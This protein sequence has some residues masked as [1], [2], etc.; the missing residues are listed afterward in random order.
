[1]Q[2]NKPEPKSPDLF[3]A[4]KELGTWPLATAPGKE[5][6]MERVAWSV[7]R[8]RWVR[9]AGHGGTILCFC[10]A[11]PVRQSGYTSLFNLL[12]YTAVVFPF[13]VVGDK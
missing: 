3:L 11:Y 2:G 8:Y 7:E 9:R 13:G 5:C 4:N 10:E 1:M 12:D 6:G